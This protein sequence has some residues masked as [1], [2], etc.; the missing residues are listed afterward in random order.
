MRFTLSLIALAAAFTGVNALDTVVNVY[1]GPTDCD[2]K[3]ESGMHLSMHY[4][5]K[6]AESSATGEKGSQFDSSRDR[7]QPF[8]FQIGVGQVIKGWDAGIIGLC[9][10][11]KATLTIPPQEGYGESGAGGAI[12]GGATLEFDVEV[13]DFGNEGPA[14]PNLFKEIDTNGDGVLDED[15]I[16]AYFKGM[17][18][19]EVPEELW[20]HEDTN[21]DRKISWEEFSG[22]KG[23]HE[24]L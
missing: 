11:A 18:M 4:V 17:G 19:D 24:E 13:L 14:Q 16:L 1:E 5:G 20:E 7:G 23:T 6:I 9:K 3:V 10:G 15:E 12:P 2:E 22:P 8:D 21:G